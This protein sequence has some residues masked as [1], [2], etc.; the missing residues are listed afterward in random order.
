MIDPEALTHAYL[1]GALDATGHDELHAWLM[2]DPAHMRRFTEALMFDEEMRR[3]VHA[4]ESVDKADRFLAP[5]ASAPLQFKAIPKTPHRLARAAVWLGAFTWFGNKAQ[6]AGAAATTLIMTKTTTTVITAT[7][8][9][10][11][12][13]SLHLLH[14]N[15]KEASARVDQL[16]ER[17]Q[18][19]L[20]ATGKRQADRG[21]SPASGAGTANTAYLIRLNEAFQVKGEG[22]A[23]EISMNPDVVKEMDQMDLETLREVLLEAREKGSNAFIL[24]AILGGIAQKSLAESTALGADILTDFHEDGVIE[25]SLRFQFS[26]TFMKWMDADRAAA[27]QW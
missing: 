17:K 9:L 5:T 21:T 27:D 2:E 12:G 20:D 19:L 7:L 14:E 1:D 22:G 25:S 16:R 3:A 23:Y 24:A 11:G 18:A 8:L 15:R 26:D 4:K 13:G 6:A 10:A